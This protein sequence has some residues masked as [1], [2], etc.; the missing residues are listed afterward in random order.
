MLHEI[1]KAKLSVGLVSCLQFKQQQT[2]PVHLLPLSETSPYMSHQSDYNVGP[3]TTHNDV[4]VTRPIYV[5][6]TQRFLAGLA[7]AAHLP[8]STSWDAN[9]PREQ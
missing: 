7:S 8:R 9:Q 1:Q 5:K 6:C 4:Q 3:P 2:S